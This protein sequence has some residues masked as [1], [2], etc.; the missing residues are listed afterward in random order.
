MRKTIFVRYTF[1]WCS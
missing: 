1:L